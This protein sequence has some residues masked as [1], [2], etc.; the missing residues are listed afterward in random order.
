[1]NGLSLYDYVVEVCA[2]C[3]C[4]KCLDSCPIYRV[5]RREGVSPRGKLKII[6]A[7]LRGEI[8]PS[9]SL[10]ENTAYCALCLACEAQCGVNKLTSTRISMG[11]IIPSFRYELIKNGYELPQYKSI[12][13]TVLR[14]GNVFGEGECRGVYN[15]AHGGNVEVIHWVGCVASVKRGSIP[16]SINNMLSRLKVSFKPLINTCCGYPLYQVGY[17]KHLEDIAEGNVEAIKSLDSNILVSS[18]PACVGFIRDF[19]PKI[20]GGEVPF[21]VKH[22][23]E[24]IQEYVKSGELKLDVRDGGIAVA[25]HDP[26]HL[27]RYLKI[28][29]QPRDVMKSLNIN[30]VEMEKNRLET[31]CCGGG[32]RLALPEI[33]T[34][35]AAQRVLAVP[36]D[37]DYLVTS[38]PTCTVNLNDGVVVARVLYDFN[39]DVKVM[40]LAEFINKFIN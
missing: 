33:S 29:D 11:E 39:V 6:H 28:Y 16:T 35:I 15:Q 40:D 38:C 8:P 14:T 12:M 23:S 26:C 19:Y 32:V 10:L 27:S 7:Y 34:T 3:R 37:V 18:C 25:Y 5:V 31:E 36:R 4:G 9:K 22:I 24:I 21:K 1:M 30:V 13:E 20:I 17:W 2:N